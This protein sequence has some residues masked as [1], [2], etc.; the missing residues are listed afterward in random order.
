MVSSVVVS[1]AIRALRPRRFGASPFL[2]LGGPNRLGVARVGAPEPTP[3]KPSLVRPR[4]R[5]VS[6]KRR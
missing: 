4:M 3:R 6:L 2:F 5:K 1:G